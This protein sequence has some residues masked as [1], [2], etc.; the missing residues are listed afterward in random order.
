MRKHFWNPLEMVRILFENPLWTSGEF[1]GFCIDSFCMLQE[2]DKD[3]KLILEH[4]S[5]K[6]IFTQKFELPSFQIEYQ[7]N[8]KVN[9][10]SCGIQLEIHWK[11][12]C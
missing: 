1:G 5:A 12:K 11:S 3:E 2:G 6:Q 10:S 8:W 9:A 7:T 4:S